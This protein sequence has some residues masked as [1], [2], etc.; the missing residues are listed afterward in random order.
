MGWLVIGNMFDLGATPHQDLYNLRFKYGPVIW[1]KFGS[2]NTMVIQSPKAAAELF[3]NHDSIFCDRKI[4][5][6]GSPVFD[7]WCLQ[8][9]LAS[10][11]L[12]GQLPRPEFRSAGRNSHWNIPLRL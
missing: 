9:G 11:G 1:L 7:Q 4:T 10:C 6:T 3:K 8:G 2:M 12:S 5:E